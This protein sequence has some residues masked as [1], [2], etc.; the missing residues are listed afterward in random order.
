M[1]PSALSQAMVS[2]M[3]LIFQKPLEGKPCIPALTGQQSLLE[4]WPFTVDQHKSYSCSS[5][6]GAT[7]DLGNEPYHCSGQL[8][9]VFINVTRGE[10]ECL[11]AKASACKIP[12]HD[13]ISLDYDFHIDSCMGIWAAPLWMTPDKWQWGPG[14]GEI[15]S[16]EFCSRDSIHLNFAGGGAQKKLDPEMFSIDDASGHVTVRKDDAGIVT[17]SA[18]TLQEAYA[19]G[20][21]CHKPN[22]TDCSSC[23]QSSNQYGCWCNENSDNIYGSGG[24]A[25]SGGGDCEWTL[26]SDIWNGVSGDSGYQGCM[27]AVPSINLPAGQPNLES[28]CSFSVERITL[29]GGGENA[30]LRWGAGSPIQ[31]A[32]LTTL[33]AR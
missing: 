32:E 25:K 28:K 26:V 23:L 15:D 4:K 18:C 29:R 31:C 19:N 20:E 33:R 30:S 6:A 16:E 24:C 9:S 21:Q 1:R 10:A 8:N 3:L 17:I 13:F 27:T 7:N 5:S 2:A 11:V 12:M 14:S 22:Y